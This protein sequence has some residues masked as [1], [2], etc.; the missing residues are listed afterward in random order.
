MIKEI[1]DIMAPVVIS[2]LVIAGLVYLLLK[3]YSPSKG[4]KN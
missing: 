4:E 1:L 3:F 2:C